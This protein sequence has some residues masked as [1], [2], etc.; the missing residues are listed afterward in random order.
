MFGTPLQAIVLLSMVALFAA[1]AVLLCIAAIMMAVGTVQRIRV[2]A[3]ERTRPPTD[4]VR[5]RRV[6]RLMLVAA[7]LTAVSLILSVLGQFI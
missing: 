4:P 1:A 2:A 7:A 5:Q 6:R 3:A